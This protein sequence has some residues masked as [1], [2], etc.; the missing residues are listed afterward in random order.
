MKSVKYI[1]YWG[2]EIYDSFPSLEDAQYVA[3][4]YKNR[5]PESSFKIVKQISSEEIVERI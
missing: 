2:D 5:Y 4:K 3:R 1:V